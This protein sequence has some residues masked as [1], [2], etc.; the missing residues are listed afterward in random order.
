MGAHLDRFAHSQSTEKKLQAFFK[1]YF[2][3]HLK[4]G[5]KKCSCLKKILGEN[6]YNSNRKSVVNWLQF[7]YLIRNFV[8]P[9]FYLHTF[10][11]VCV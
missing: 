1:I 8:F 11:C 6:D 2:D 9:F 5:E 4:K 3:F 10:M 7:E